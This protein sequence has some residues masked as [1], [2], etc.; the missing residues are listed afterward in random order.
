M[1]EEVNKLGFDNVKN[2]EQASQL[3]EKLFDVARPGAVFS[4][5]TTAGDRTVITASEVR[6]GMGFGYGGG[7]GTGPADEEGGEAQSGVGGG[8]GGGGGSAGRPVAVISI[9][10]EGVRVEPV[11]D[12]TKISLAMFTTLGSMFL[13]LRNMRRA[14]KG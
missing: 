8:G 2:L 7:G 11:V 3:M 6:V 13:M 10:P 12:V 14:S 4:Q 5:P 9:G 1:S